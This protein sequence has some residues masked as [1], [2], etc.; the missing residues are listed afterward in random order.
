MD[1]YELDSEPHWI[2]EKDW[3][4]QAI[5]VLKRDPSAKTL[6]GKYK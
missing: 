1:L 3:I 2:D 6:A 5:P 4:V